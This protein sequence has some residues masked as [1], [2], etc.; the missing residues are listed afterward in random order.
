MSIKK[1]VNSHLNTQDYLNCCCDESTKIKSDRVMNLS[2]IT[3]KGAFFDSS[4]DRGTATVS[5]EFCAD[6]AEKRLQT[7]TRGKMSR[8]N[9]FCTDTCS[10]MLS[11]Q[12]ETRSPAYLYDLLRS[13]WPT[14]RYCS[15]IMK[16][17]EP[18]S[19]SFCRPLPQASSYSYSDT[20]D[21]AT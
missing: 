21:F 17:Y 13:S 11:A 6:L 12:A 16:H 2:L 8:V 3:E 14:T 10:P 1:E 4:I 15:L 5:A 20:A 9:S 18:G 19:S 7:V